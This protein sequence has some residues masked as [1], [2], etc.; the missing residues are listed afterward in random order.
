VP[1]PS[2]DPI[3]L[4]SRVG[5][6]ELFPALLKRQQPVELTTLPFGDVAFVGRGPS[7][8]EVIGV[9]RKTIRDLAQS[10]M[11]DRLI[12]HQLP[13]LVEAYRF[14]FLV[15]EG[16]YRTGDLGYLE[17]P[18]AGSWVPL[19][20]RLLATGLHGWLLTLQLRGGIF[21]Q[22]TRSLDDTAEWLTSLY[23]WWTGKAWR[24]HRGH[25]AIGV[26]PDASL[27]IKPSLL[28]RVASELP[29]V[30]L[31]KSAA[32]EAAFDS[33]RAMA[34]AEE[35]RW[36]SIPGIGKILSARI[37]QALTAAPGKS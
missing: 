11:S 2:D 9:E 26:Q 23:A 24:E 10:L 16:S 4:D 7:G 8:P 15:V 31:E 29:G 14:R 5:S 20:P 33:V 35:A 37:V 18:T 1:N 12:G 19:Q 3:Y 22:R 36:R 27:F 32:V 13:G 6:K 25:L 17:I 30:G 28:R 21:V 34:C